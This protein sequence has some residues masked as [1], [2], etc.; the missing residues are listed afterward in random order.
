VR[1][2]YRKIRYLRQNFDEEVGIQRQVGQHENF[3]SAAKLYLDVKGREV[4]VEAR[5]NGDVLH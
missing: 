2:I 3:V 5:I 1:V 4:T